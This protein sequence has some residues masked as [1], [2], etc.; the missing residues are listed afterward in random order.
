MK[1]AGR[2]YGS[3]GICGICVVCAARA[4]ALG[5]GRAH[6][7]EGL[8]RSCLSIQ[9]Q[10]IQYSGVGRHNAYRDCAGAVA[11]LA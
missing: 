10:F 5:V 1:A 2:P 3:T 9:A 8:W 4:P 7:V 11:Y 6:D